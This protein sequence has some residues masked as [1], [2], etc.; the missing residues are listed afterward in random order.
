MITGATA[1]TPSI[2]R[3]FAAIDRGS[4]SIWLTRLVVIRTLACA[5]ATLVERLLTKPCSTA[6]SR[7]ALTIDR[8]VRMA[9]AGF[10]H[11][12]AQISGMNLT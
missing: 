10:R 6:N 11:M 12:P 4:G 8:R 1:W 5:S 3:I 2:V 9:R 7:K